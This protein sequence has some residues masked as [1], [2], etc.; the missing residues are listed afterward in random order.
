[1]KGEEIK[2]RTRR[3]TSKEIIQGFPCTNCKVSPMAGLLF[4]S[5]I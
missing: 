2:E 4:L 1:M 5:E 3:R